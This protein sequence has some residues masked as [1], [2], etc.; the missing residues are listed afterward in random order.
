MIKKAGIII[1]LFLLILPV[2]STAQRWKRM[3]YEVV[4]GVGASNFLGE[5]GGADRIGTNYFRDLE[6]AMTR[7]VVSLGL[8]Y[9]IVKWLALKGSLTYA[10]INGD[11]RLTQEVSR[12]YRNLSFRSPIVEFEVRLEPAIIKE[13]A[14][15]RYRLRGVK[16]K[17]WL[18]INTY[19][20]IGIAAFYFNPKAKY[21]GKWYSLQPLI[22]EGQGIFP[23]RKKYS[24]F[25][26]SIPVGIGFK[27][28]LNRRYSIGLEYGLRKTFTDYLDDVSTTY[29]HPDFIRAEVGG[30]EGELAAILADRSDGSQPGKT[31]AGQQRGDPSDKDAYMFAIVSLNYKFNWKRRRRK[32]RKR[33]ERGKKRKRGGKRVEKKEERREERGKEEKRRRGKREEGRRK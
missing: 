26:V 10:R 9:R 7:P 32:E 30:K 1:L 22:T 3:R 14:G 33:K 12:N 28:G 2:I 13:Q 5:L 27:Y 15:R 23:T 4:Y 17:R 11:D 19:P 21:Q 31:A 16:G 24:R 20:I 6:M 25:G 8:R 18:M 29:V